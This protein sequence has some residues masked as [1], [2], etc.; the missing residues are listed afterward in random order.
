MMLPIQCLYIIVL[1]SQVYAAPGVYKIRATTSV[2]S[3]SVST[4]PKDF[5]LVRLPGN[6][7][8]LSP[9]EVA[10]TK[11]RKTNVLPRAWKQ[12]LSNVKS[13]H[14]QLPSYV[15]S[16]LSGDAGWSTP[17]LGIAASGGGYRATIFGAGIL[18][19]LDARNASSA[20]AGTGGLLQAAGY[21]SGLSGGSWLVSSL[22]QAEFP[23]I[24]HLVFGDS[25][26]G[27]YAGWLAQYTLL[28]PSSIPTLLA[29]MQPKYAKGFDVTINDVWAR[30]SARHFL[31]GTT[32]GNIQNIS[33]HGGDILVSGFTKLSVFVYWWVTLLN[34]SKALRSKDTS[35]RSPSSL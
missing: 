33:S 25:S 3:L 5:T 11:S 23:T 14:I 10:Y 7:A 4:C 1:A 29:E 27:S 22:V 18:N 13:T 19:V 15:T 16:I 26:Q 24:Q 32:S 8:Q 20:K 2:D 17:N 9:S 6:N 34:L 30:D 35:S 12:Y 28:S 21:L 31:N